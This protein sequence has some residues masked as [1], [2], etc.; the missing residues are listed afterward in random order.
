MRGAP[1]G[2]QT[3]ELQ[4][5]AQLNFTPC[6]LPAPDLNFLQVCTASEFA[7]LPGGKVNRR[8]VRTFGAIAIRHVATL[9]GILTFLIA[10]VGGIFYSYGETWRLQYV[11]LAILVIVLSTVIIYL[12]W[13]ILTKTAPEFLGIPRVIKV[14]TEHRLLLVE[15]APW[16]SVGVMIATYVME[17]DMERL[18]GVGEVVNVQSNGLVQLSVQ[19]H[20]RGYS[21]D[22]E[23]W[24]FLNDA[25]REQIIVR[26]GL[27]RGAL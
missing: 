15:Q 24:N 6:V 2:H 11:D 18:I 16:L 7:S 19:P 9:A 25:K 3:R 26:P 12:A 14:L 5:H 20:E 4:S 22:N 10:V 21:T 17:S 1:F 27:M 13:L 8:P 23:I